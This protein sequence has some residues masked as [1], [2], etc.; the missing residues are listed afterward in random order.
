M[1]IQASRIVS[2]YVILYVVSVSM[3]MLSGNSLVESMPLAILSTLCKTIVSH[4]HAMLWQ[5]KEIN[6]ANAPAVE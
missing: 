3:F 6:G 2:L 5:R 4:A 1:K